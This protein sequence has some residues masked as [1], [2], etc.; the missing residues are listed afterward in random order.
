M[1]KPASPI[2]DSEEIP[3]GHRRRVRARR[4][5][6]LPKYDVVNPRSALGGGYT[7]GMGL[8]RNSGV[9]VKMTLRG[10]RVGSLK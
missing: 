8:I 7:W 6:K 9:V 5:S 10:V 2:T 3:G 4:K 1:K